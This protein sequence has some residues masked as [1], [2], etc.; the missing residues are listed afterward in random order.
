MFV[1]KYPISYIFSQFIHFKVRQ[2]GVLEPEFY[3]PMMSRG[4]EKNNVR[5]GGEV[6]GFWTIIKTPVQCRTIFS[7]QYL[8][9]GV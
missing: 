2:L 5:K 6:Y 4:G 8:S 7:V 1:L 9:L 3:F